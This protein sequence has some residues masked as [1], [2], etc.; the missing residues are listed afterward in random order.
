MLPVSGTFGHCPFSHMLDNETF[1][2][3]I[4][5]FACKRPRTQSKN[6]HIHINKFI[7]N[8][9]NIFESPCTP[10]ITDHINQYMFLFYYLIMT[11]FLPILL[12]MT[13]SLNTLNPLDSN[14]DS[15]L[16]LGSPHYLIPFLA[17][18]HIKL[19]SVIVFSWFLR[20]FL[21][22]G[23]MNKVKYS[24]RFRRLVSLCILWVFSLNFILITLVNPSMLN[25]GPNSLSVLYQNVQGLIPFSNLSSS[26]PLLDGNKISELQSFANIEQPDIIAL[27]ETWLKK[28]IASN[29]ILPSSQ[30]EVFRN[31]RSSNPHGLIVNSFPHVVKKIDSEI[32]LRYLVLFLMS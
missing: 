23:K 4:G 27:N 2:L 7:P 32:N 24:S 3:R 21:L 13:K 12:S 1:R 17:C 14:I 31:D 18:S 28:S 19:F 22:P 26:H 30:Y 6:A 11:Y 15:S 16:L 9:I 8:K 25:P 10:H 5:L 29:E 20:N